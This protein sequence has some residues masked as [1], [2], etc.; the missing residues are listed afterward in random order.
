AVAAGRPSGPV[1]ASRPRSSCRWSSCHP[2][3]LA[4]QL[5]CSCDDVC[6]PEI[7]L[8]QNRGLVAVLIEAS[9][10]AGSEGVP[11]FLERKEVPHG[12]VV[13]VDVH[14]ASSVIPKWATTSS[15]CR[16]TNRSR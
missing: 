2:P 13:E 4:L 8:V 5:H 1:R 15:Q 14:A 7:L 11:F 16:R 10:L 3:E 9:A 12:V 6:H